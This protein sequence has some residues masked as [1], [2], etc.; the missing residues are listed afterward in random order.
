M[1]ADVRA[2]VR[3]GKQTCKRRAGGRVGGRVGRRVGRRV[4]KRRADGGQTCGQTRGQTC[5]QKGRA[6]NKR[7]GRTVS[8]SS[9]AMT[10]PTL[11]A[12][13]QSLQ[14]T[15]F[16][17]RPD[18]LALPHRVGSRAGIN[19]DDVGVAPDPPVAESATFS[20]IR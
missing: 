15:C 11:V 7:G 13:L 8:C 17:K 1:R 5:G 10:C 4:G 19:V 12:S 16:W 9:M 14:T 3:A 2:D 20:S 6:Q 18:N